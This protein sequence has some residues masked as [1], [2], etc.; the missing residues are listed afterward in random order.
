MGARLTLCVY[1]CAVYHH[2][3]STY[4]KTTYYWELSFRQLVVRMICVYHFYINH[5]YSD[6]WTL[7]MASKVFQRIFMVCMIMQIIKFDR[8]SSSSSSQPPRA[9]Q[10]I[11]PENHTFHLNTD[12]LHA[13]FDDPNL[14]HRQLVVVS[15][16]GPHRYGKSFLMNFF[17]RYLEAQVNWWAK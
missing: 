2:L 1:M 17:I 16:A 10:I 11:V 12:A 3:I 15:I 6:F 14:K 4:W 5:I 9:I 7:T 13:I 8:I